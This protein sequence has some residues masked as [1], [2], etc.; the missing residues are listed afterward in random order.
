MGFQLLDDGTQ[1]TPLLIPVSVSR[2]KEIAANSKPIVPT[3]DSDG[4]PRPNS[5][6][7]VASQDCAIV[8]YLDILTERTPFLCRRLSLPRLKQ[9]CS[10]R[11][12]SSL[13]GPEINRNSWTPR[14]PVEAESHLDSLFSINSYDTWL[15]CESHRTTESTKSGIAHNYLCDPVCG[16]SVSSGV[17]LSKRKLV[18]DKLSFV[19]DR[20]CR[21]FRLN[22]IFNTPESQELFSEFFTLDLPLEISQDRNEL[23]Y[24]RRINLEASPTKADE[25]SLGSTSF[26]EPTWKKR[27]QRFFDR[28]EVQ[29]PLVR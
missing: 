18:G 10:L 21:K 14:A 22:R 9:P 28:S 3:D 16:P 27:F 12:Q 29:A 17:P 13:R 23:D 1:V 4:T 24:L 11:R 20:F 26:D 15:P 2:I 19:K 5:N 7:T 8:R 25:S 6:V